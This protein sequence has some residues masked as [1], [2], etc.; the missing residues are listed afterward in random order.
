MRNRDLSIFSGKYSICIAAFACVAALMLFVQSADAR[1]GVVMMES[2][3]GTAATVAQGGHSAIYLSET[4][5]DNY[6][7]LRPCTKKDP[8]WGV[9]AERTASF[10]EKAKYDWLVMPVSL[11]LFAAQHADSEL[12]VVNPHFRKSLIKRFY[13]QNAAFRNLVVNS[14]PEFEKGMKL[15]KEYGFPKGRWQNFFGSQLRRSLY[16]VWINDKSGKKEHELVEAI[17]GFS[18]RPKYNTLLFL[19]AGNCAKWVNGAL[20]QID[21]FRKAGFGVNLTGDG[22][23]TSPKGVT[24]EAFNAAKRIMAKDSDVFVTV[25]LLPQIP[26]TYE[27]SSPPFYIIESAFKNKLV[28]PVI[29]FFHPLVFLI[30]RFYFKF[31]KRFSIEQ[32]YRSYFN[33]EAATLSIRGETSG[34]KKS[35]KKRMNELRGQFFG[36]KDW[37]QNK[38]KRFRVIL[39]R[40]KTAGLIAKVSDVQKQKLLKRLLDKNADLEFDS[41]GNPWFVRLQANGKR[42]KTG[43]TLKTVDKGDRELGLKILLARIQWQLKQKNVDQRIQKARFEKEWEKLIELFQHLKLGKLA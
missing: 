14:D 3:P 12:L 18:N 31:I 33:F 17:N 27:K 24:E 21:D 29:A 13:F 23:L 11:S 39:E 15:D 40:A 2:I 19:F 43:L 38:K 16:V 32:R 22:F 6:V 36:S 7:E 41:L 37:W 5:T 30:G 1:I 10:S 35:R 9:V 28:W 8:I 42:V 25:E 20:L 4:C 34:P 26:G